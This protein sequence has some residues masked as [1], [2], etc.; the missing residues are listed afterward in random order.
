MAHK[1]IPPP[2]DATHIFSLTFEWCPKLGKKTPEKEMAEVKALLVN[3]LQDDSM[4][5]SQER[6]EEIKRQ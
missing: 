5:I 1:K 2:K 3:L 4:L 6:I